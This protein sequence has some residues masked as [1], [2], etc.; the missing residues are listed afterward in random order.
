MVDTQAKCPLT[1]NGLTAVRPF[2]GLILNIADDTG[3]F[4]KTD[5]IAIDDSCTT[6]LG[7]GPNTNKIEGE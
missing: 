2:H 5:I 1:K 6:L 4:L 3:Q 7:E